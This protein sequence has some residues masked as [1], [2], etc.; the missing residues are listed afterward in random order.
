MTPQFHAPF[1]FGAIGAAAAA[2]TA[3]FALAYPGLARADGSPAVTASSVTPLATGDTGAFKLTTLARSALVD[4]TGRGQVQICNE[5]G[6]TSALDEASAMP[7][8]TP[9]GASTLQVSYDG[10][11]AQ[12]VP[13]A[14]YRISAPQVRITT[15]APLG[16]GSTLEGT[17]EQ[18][19]PVRAG[20]VTVSDHTVGGN[21]EPVS[22]EL[23]QI[24]NELKQDDRTTR[25]ARAELERA[26]REFQ[27]AARELRGQPVA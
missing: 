23:R 11:T 13:G 1:R 2:A 18:V 26:S 8:F 15:N 5:T 24:R 14:C 16:S 19:A 21:A 20:R 4:N 27:L 10:A 3:C 25:Q 6:R 9:S 12:I 17:L 7:P 22:M